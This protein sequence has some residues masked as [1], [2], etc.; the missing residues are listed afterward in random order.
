MG[1]KNI[2]LYLLAVICGVFHPAVGSAAEKSSLNLVFA[3]ALD[4]DLYQVMTAGGVSY[5][6]HDSALKAV[7]AAPEGAGVLILADHYPGKTTEIAPL[8]FELATQKKLRLYI[9]YPAVVPDF[10]F[11]RPKQ[12]HWER[13]VVASDIFGTE[14]EKLRILQIH[15]CH[16]LP[17]QASRAHLVSARVAGYDKAVYGLPEKNWP[18]LFEHPRGDMLIATTKLSQFVS[19]RYAPTKAWGPVWKMVL[20]WLSPDSN[21]PDL[22]WTPTV[23]PS[24]VR[25]ESLP[26]NAERVAFRRGMKWFEGFLVDESWKDELIHPAKTGYG[27]ADTKPGLNRPLGDGRYGILEGHIS[28]VF[29]DGSQ[30]MRWLLRGDCNAESAMAFALSGNLENDSR[31]K[32]IAANIMDFVYFKSDLYQSDP[33]SP[34]YGLLGWYS[35]GTGPN[36]FWG[37]DGSKAIIGS[38]TAASALK[39]QRWD[40]RIL[41][42][43]LANFRTTGPFGFR[44]GMPL[45]A[46]QLK[47][48]GWEHYARRRSIAPWPQREAWAWACYLWLYDKTGYTPLY[49][50][51]RK[52]IQITMQRYPDGWGYAL[53]EMQMERGRMLLPLAWLVRVD[54]T[55]EHRAWLRRVVDDMLVRQD[56]S[57]AIQEQLRFKSHKSNEDYGTGEVSI[58]HEDG[59]PCADVFYS[60]P[61]AFIGLVEAAAAT[62]DPKYVQAVDKVAEFLVRAQ[63]RSE[64]HPRL[65]GGWFRAFDIKRWDYWGANGDSGWGAWSSETGWVQSHIVAAIAMREKKSSLWDF[66]ADNT[67]GLHFERYRKIMEIDK[68]VAVMKAARSQQVKHL[69]LNKPVKAKTTPHPKH[70]GAGTAGLTDGELGEPKDL[71]LGWMGFRGADLDATIDLGKETPL[72]SVKANFLELISGGI[73]LPREI[74]LAVSDDGKAFHTVATQQFNLPKKGDASSQLSVKPLQLSLNNVSSRY[75]RFRA[76]SIGK[77]PPWHPAAGSPAWLFVDEIVVK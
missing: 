16:F 59:D 64:V 51:A 70:P 11:G 19:A 47:K 33:R 27:P 32:A 71:R 60:V 13:T 24:F 14:L 28:K 54:D 15:D 52:A 55:L 20:G 73:L 49:D 31:H 46:S 18:L 37:N 29:S 22:E 65:D 23:R 77:L 40:E 72:Q 48:H 12:P 6:R 7:L 56:A 35:Y 39:N 45:N 67:I 44:D 61:P 34:T 30:P 8:V 58:L 10:E 42:S 53:H 38:L 50:Q 1:H 26:K 75:L 74:E 4:N 41:T 25:N 9:E 21:I 17:V 69:A 3:C 36:A 68:A 2:I 66:T 63:V 43:I 57:G 62:G 5:L 76:K